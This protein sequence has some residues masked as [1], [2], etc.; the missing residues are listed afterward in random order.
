[1]LFLMLIVTLLWQ[2]V[3]SATVEFNPSTNRDPFTSLLPKEKPIEQPTVIAPGTREEVI[4]APKLNI[5][6]LV[7]G[8][9]FPQAI[10]ENKVVKIGDKIDE[11]EIVE[12]KKDGIVITYKGKLFT[13]Q[14]QG[15]SPGR[16]TEGERR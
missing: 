12:I 8:A 6:G 4:V 11:S 2:E 10:I 7:W 16:S 13:L 15:P 14:T 5:Q 9:K 3:V 1:M